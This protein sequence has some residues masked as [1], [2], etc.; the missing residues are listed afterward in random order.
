[1]NVADS[2]TEY[3][4]NFNG[5]PFGYKRIPKTLFPILLQK[6]KTVDDVK[7]LKNIIAD[8]LCHRNRISNTD[9]DNFMKLGVKFDAVEMLDYFT[10]HRQLFYYPHPSVLD[11]YVDYF[12][13]QQNY[14]E[15]A[16][17]LIES[18]AEEFWILKTDKYF[19]ELIR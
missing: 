5:T 15:N 14:E 19:N 17:K 6:V 9:M 16:K 1:M 7:A 11:L 4:D 13:Q 8:I 10:Y 3:L 18:T 12:T 2:F